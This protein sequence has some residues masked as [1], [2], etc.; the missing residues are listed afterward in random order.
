[1]YINKNY[2]SYY[3]YPS[4]LRKLWS[5]RKLVIIICI[6]TVCKYFIF[7]F[8]VNVKMKALPWLLLISNAVKC[9]ERVIGTWYSL[10]MKR[11]HKYFVC[12]SVQLTLFNKSLTWHSESIYSWHS[13]ISV[14]ISP[15]VL[16]PHLV[17]SATM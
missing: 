3:Y 16:V 11:N 17:V 10:M 2:A 1:M 5:K 6:D 14:F 9:A 4:N 7:L 8:F 12:R 13:C 15:H